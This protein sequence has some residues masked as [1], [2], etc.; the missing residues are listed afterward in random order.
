MT[1]DENGQYIGTLPA[2]S[3]KYTA[4]DGKGNTVAGDF[5][6][7][8]DMTIT[9]GVAFRDLVKNLGIYGYI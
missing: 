2:G 4:A 9:V 5:T 8:K 6:I 1:T 3:Y 7:V